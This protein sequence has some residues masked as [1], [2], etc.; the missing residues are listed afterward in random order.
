MQVMKMKDFI[1]RYATTDDAKEILGIYSYYVENTA[2]SYETETP[3][4][5]EYKGRME[6]IMQNYPFFVAVSDGKI[7]GFAYAN[8]MS[9]RKAYR[10]SSEL[11][12]YVSKD[13]KKCGIGSSLYGKIESLLKEKGITNL[14]ARVA[15]PVEED[16]YLTTDSEKFH[17]KMGFT[18][19]GC[20]NKCGYKFGRRYNML[21]ME[22]IIGEHK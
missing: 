8:S 14:Y 20:L 13:S 12:V 21:Y 22:K 18:R 4:L 5:D 19:V 11:S 9:E 6:K 16:E 10:K 3:A 7:I 15:S 2:I 17:E 1:I